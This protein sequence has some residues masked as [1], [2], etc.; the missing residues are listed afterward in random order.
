[1][2]TPPARKAFG[3][4]LRRLRQKRGHTAAELA[5]MLSE[6]GHHTTGSNIGAW[7]RGQYVPRDTRVVDALA[8]VLEAGTELH[9]PLSLERDAAASTSQDYNSRI[10]RL[11]PEAQ[12]VIDTIIEA[13]ERKLES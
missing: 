12:S 5:K 4:A 9:K 8:V 7:E 1:M 10:T 2:A 3:N 11:S 6:R 13:E